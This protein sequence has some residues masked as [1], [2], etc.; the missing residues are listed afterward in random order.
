MRGAGSWGVALALGGGRD[1]TRAPGFSEVWGLGTVWGQ[2]SQSPLARLER[3]PWAPCAGRGLWLRRGTVQ[4]SAPVEECVFGGF[5]G[6]V[7]VPGGSLGVGRWHSSLCV[8][9]LAGA[10][11][12]P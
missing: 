12:R 4:T 6:L 5:L 8:G 1:G 3:G 10:D 9:N 7:S 2:C 11:G